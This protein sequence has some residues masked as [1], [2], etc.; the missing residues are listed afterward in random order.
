VSN[1]THT[2]LPLP[3]CPAS[4]RHF[5]LIDLQIFRT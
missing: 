1:D 2:E 5:Y 3:Y 4:R